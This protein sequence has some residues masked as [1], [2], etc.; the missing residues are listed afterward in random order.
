MADP[1]AEFTNVSKFQAEALGEPG[2]RAF[3]ILVNS[4]SSGATIW[5]EKE[6][7]LQMALALNQLVAAAPEIPD[8]GATLDLTS[9]EAP[10][11]TNIEFKLGKMVLGIEGTIRKFIID[12]YEESEDHGAD[13]FLRIW[14]DQEQFIEF[15]EEA[16]RVVASGRPICPLCYQPIDSDGHKCARTN[17]HGL[18]SIDKLEPPE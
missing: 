3:R 6:Q 11:A 14:G 13:A 4:G 16:L 17:G 8:G 5:L 1:H 12:V 10:P 18:H 2:K 15:A 7:L 9:R